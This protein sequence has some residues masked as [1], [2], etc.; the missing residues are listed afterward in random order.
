[1]HFPGN[2]RKRAFPWRTSPVGAA[3]S[4]AV[5]IAAVASADG[6]TVARPRPA[7]LPRPGRWAALPDQH[8]LDHLPTAGAAW[9]EL[10]PDFLAMSGAVDNFSASRHLSVAYFLGKSAAFVSG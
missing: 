6:C 5:K 3:L 2:E 7:A 1:M 9:R 8:H 10:V 4:A